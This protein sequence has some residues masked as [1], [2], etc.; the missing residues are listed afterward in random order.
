M[1]NIRVR[2]K[3][4]ENDYKI[5]LE[6]TKMIVKENEPSSTNIMNAISVTSPATITA[7]SWV[8][9]AVLA[10]LPIIVAILV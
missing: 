8:F 10:I 7:T 3:N 4:V 5:Y 9:P 1:S 2:V 6:R